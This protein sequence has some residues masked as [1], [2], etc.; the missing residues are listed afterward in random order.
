MGPDASAYRALGLEPGADAAVVEAVYRELIKRHHPDRPGGDPERAAEIN[1]AYHHIR[2]MQQLP[3]TGRDLYPVAHPVRPASPQSKGRW[4]GLTLAAAAVALVVNAGAIERA[5][6]SFEGRSH[7]SEFRRAGAVDPPADL[8]DQ[9][10]DSDAID[11]SVLSAVRLAR[12][13]N[14]DRLATQSRRCHAELQHSPGLSR[15]DQCVAFDE[16]VVVIM[17][18]KALESGQFDASAVTGRQL[19]AARL[20]SGGYSSIES[21]VNRI[22]SHVEFSLAPPDP[23]PVPRLDL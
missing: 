12:A 11:R 22:R 21:R 4:L 5:L 9:P 8:S 2:K 14:I 17:A 19:S 6:G 10:L 20:F 1:W 23:Q 16:A 3:A 18:G 13:G 7:G 15:L